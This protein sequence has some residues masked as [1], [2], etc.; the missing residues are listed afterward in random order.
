LRERQGPP[1]LLATLCVAQLPDEPVR[2][3]V[4]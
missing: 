4:T 1:A 2:L 3:L